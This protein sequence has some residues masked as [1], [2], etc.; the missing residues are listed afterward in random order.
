MRTH[1]FVLL[2][3]MLLAF[4]VLAQAQGNSHGYLLA[5]PGGTAPSGGGTLHL[6]GGGDGVFN[7]GASVG[8]EVG[9]LFPFRDASSGLGLFSVNGGY[10]FLKSGS[11]AVPFITGG[12]TGFFRDGYANGVNFGGGV[13]YWFKERVGVRIEFRDNI[14]A[15]D[16]DA[17]H[18]LNVRFGI[19]FR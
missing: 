8:A 9:Y 6:A 14:A 3:A 7:N 17:V 12:Y 19:T 18:F 1:R 4:A 10:H 15:F 11:K 5:A 13:N 16:G 2:V